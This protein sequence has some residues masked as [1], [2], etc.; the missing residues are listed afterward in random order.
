MKIGQLK[1]YPENFSA[2]RVAEVTTSLKSG[3]F[4]TTWGRGVSQQVLR[5][6]CRQEIVLF[7]TRF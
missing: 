7:P 5:G 6:G 3:R 1:K 2:S 4:W